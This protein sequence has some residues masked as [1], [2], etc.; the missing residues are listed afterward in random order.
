MKASAAAQSKRRSRPLTRP[1]IPNFGVFSI[2]SLALVVLV[3]GALGLLLAAV[4]VFGLAAVGGSLV[5][6]VGYGTACAFAIAAIAGVVMWRT[7][8]E[9]AT[10]WP[11]LLV[12]VGIGAAIWGLFAV[13]PVRAALLVAAIATL[14]VMAWLVVVA[15]A[16]FTEPQGRSGQRERWW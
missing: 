10:S 4:G 7:G 12:C 14:L 16:F 9:L 5:A 13:G 1:D 2:V 6:K 8:G 3:V 15:V 11:V